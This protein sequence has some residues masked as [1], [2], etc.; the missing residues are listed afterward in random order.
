MMNL[1]FVGSIL[2]MIP[3]ISSPVLGTM[4]MRKYHTPDYLEL[5]DK[6]DFADA[7]KLSI[8]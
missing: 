3:K 8:S 4:N 1:I 6:R 5:L 2:K 7:L